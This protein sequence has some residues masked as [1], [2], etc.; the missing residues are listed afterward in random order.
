MA[1]MTPSYAAALSIS[2]SISVPVAARAPV[3]GSDRGSA[4]AP[5][6]GQR[7]A[8]VTTATT[9]AAPSGTM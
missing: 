6:V 3:K 4:R 2:H 8:P 5:A 7:R 9:I 1:R